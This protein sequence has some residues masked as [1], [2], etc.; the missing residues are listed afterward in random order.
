MT[1]QEGTAQ[2]KKLFGSKA[3]VEPV[4]WKGDTEPRAWSVNLDLDSIVDLEIGRGK[5]IEEAI[6]KAVITMK[7]PDSTL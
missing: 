7:T 2:A 4:L 5:T 1:R 3:Y 6:A